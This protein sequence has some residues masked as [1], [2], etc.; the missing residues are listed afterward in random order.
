[1]TQRIEGKG[2]NQGEIIT[3]EEEAEDPGEHN[4]GRQGTKI[5]A[6]DREEHEKSAVNIRKACQASFV[7]HVGGGVQQ[8]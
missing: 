2:C 4:T 3:I 8:K 5:T 1:M 6:R 7:L